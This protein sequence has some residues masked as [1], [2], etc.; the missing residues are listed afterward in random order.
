LYSSQRWDAPDAD[1]L[2]VSIIVL[3]SSLLIITALDLVTGVEPADVLVEAHGLLMDIVLF[4]CLILWFNLRRDKRERIRRYRETLEDFRDWDTKEGVLRKVGAINRLLDVD[5][6]KCLPYLDYQQLPGANFQGVGLE[7]VTLSFANLNNAFLNGANFRSADLYGAQLVEA[8]LAWAACENADLRGVNLRGADLEGIKLDGAKL[9]N[10]TVG[11]SSVNGPIT[12]VTDL[13]GVTGLTPDAL[14][15][16]ENWEDCYR[17]PEFACGKAIP[18]PHGHSAR[19]T[20][21]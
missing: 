11:Q 8:C 16:A 4:G 21:G 14:V 13:R 18:S 17:D 20:I 12:Y 2:R 6:P 15:V 19:S 1:E 7:G 5:G 10:I 9:G 3:I